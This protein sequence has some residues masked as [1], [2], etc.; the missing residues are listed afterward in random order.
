MMYGIIDSI[1]ANDRTRH[2][3]FLSPRRLRLTY[4][5]AMMLPQ[6][7]SLADYHTAKQKDV[8]DFFAFSLC[9]CP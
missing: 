9:C 2:P 5:F 3:S 1:G 7:S 8:R 6:V 4:A